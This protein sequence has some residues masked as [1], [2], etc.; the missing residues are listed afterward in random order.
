M[1]RKAISIVVIACVGALALCASLLTGTSAL[2]ASSQSASDNQYVDPLSG[3]GQARTAPSAE[4]TTAT[5]RTNGGRSTDY[6]LS[7]AVAVGAGLIGA[8]ALIRRRVGAG[9]AAHR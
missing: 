8:A 5:N 3:S 9:G 7:L 4:T 2:A 1:R 6:V